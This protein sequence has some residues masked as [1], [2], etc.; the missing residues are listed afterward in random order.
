LSVCRCTAHA[1]DLTQLEAITAVYDAQGMDNVAT[2]DAPEADAGAAAAAAGGEIDEQ[3]HKRR[4]SGGG[5]SVSNTERAIDGF[6]RVMTSFLP[7]PTPGQMTADKWLQSCMVTA[8]Q[9]ELIKAELPAAEEAMSCLMLS[10][11]DD[12]DFIKIELA[13]KQIKAWKA[14]AATFK[15]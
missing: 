4:R 6:A 9:R 2:P 13:P 12:A 5:S 3:Q 1:D 10:T 7:P 14:L 11:F 8:Q 15:P